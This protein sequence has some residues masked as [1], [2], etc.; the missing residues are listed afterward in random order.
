MIIRFWLLYY[1]L[2]AES[3]RFRMMTFINDLLRDEISLLLYTR[4]GSYLYQ[5]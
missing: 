4:Q 3:L 2:V 5:I 1:C